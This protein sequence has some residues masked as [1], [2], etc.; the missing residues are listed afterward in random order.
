M[1]SFRAAIFD[2]DGTLLDT[3][4]DL[5]CALDTALVRHGFSKKTLAH[6]KAAIGNGLKKYAERSIPK[7]HLTPELLD[8]ITREVRDY[9]REHSTVYTKPYDGICEVLEGM[10]DKGIIL[11]ILSNKVDAF[12]RELAGYY[13]DAG[14]FQCAYGEREHVPKKPD[15]A[16][17]LAIAEELGIAPKDILFI[18]DSIYDVQTGKAAGMHTVAV[19]WGYQEEERLKGESPDFIAHTPE[20]LMEYV[21]K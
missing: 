5:G 17:A 14:I 15:P 11:T 12:V 8:E 21:C 1:K 18:G 3:I 10:R 6:H 20:E 7:E 19:T 9:Y 2:L 13:F 16:A 4:A